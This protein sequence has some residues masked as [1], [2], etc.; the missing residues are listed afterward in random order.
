MFRFL[1]R[2]PGSEKGQALPIVLALLAIGGLTIAVNLRYGT[3]CLN[4]SRVFVE[5]IKGIY[6]ASAGVENS[7]WSLK[8]G[9][10]PPT[11]LSQNIN[12]MA[13]GIQTLYQGAFTL[14]FGEMI[15]VSSVHSDWL[16]V[17][18]NITSLGGGV[19]R[20][21]ITVTWQPISDDPIIKL[22]EVGAR[23]PIGYSYQAG[24]AD[25]EGNLQRS[26]SEL[27]ITTDPYGAYLL[28]WDLGTPRP[29]V[30]SSQPTRTQIFD[31]EGTGSTS[32]H[33][34]NVLA[35]PDSIGP[36]GEIT[37]TRYRI[38]A[39]A[40]RPEGGKTTAEIV[41][42]AIIRDDGTIDIA[43]WQITK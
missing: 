2:L 36:V 34:A 41:A 30:S 27:T 24:S 21:T 17:S 26:D 32:G 23:I 35:Q 8:K 13:V 18:G 42:D 19:Y 9:S 40:T 11:Q 4:G 37:G 33:Y 5:D 1:K 25:I 20:Y 31:I 38:T 28:K 15:D 7:L 39:T 6:A 3:T 16:D 14:Y 29:D 12:D 10:V 43:S 22:E